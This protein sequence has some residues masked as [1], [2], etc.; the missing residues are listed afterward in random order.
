[1]QKNNILLT[2]TILPISFFPLLWVSNDPL[3]KIIISIV[4]LCLTPFSIILYLKH[5]KDDKQ[6]YGLQLISL[7]II[8]MVA[9]Y[10]GS[11]GFTLK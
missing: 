9:V 1:M 6:K 10:F 2:I 8:A 3:V 7:I 4:I 11:S 5:I